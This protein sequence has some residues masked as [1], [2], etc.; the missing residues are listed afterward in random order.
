MTATVTEQRTERL[1]KLHADHERLTLVSVEAVEM[2]DM[3]ATRFKSDFAAAVVRRLRNDAQQARREAVLRREQYD[4][5]M[6]H[7]QAAD[8]ET[9]AAVHREA[10]AI[11]VAAATPPADDC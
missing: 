6:A 10:E 9:A 8:V 4:T 1:A 11:T 3:I 2:A 7:V 5:L